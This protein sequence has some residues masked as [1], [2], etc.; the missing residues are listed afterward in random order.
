MWSAKRILAAG[1]ALAL[2][3]GLSA[4][5]TETSEMKEN[6]LT[7][8]AAEKTRTYE[9]YQMVEGNIEKTGT[10]S[11]TPIYTQTQSLCAPEDDLL[12]DRILVDRKQRVSEGEV[13]A[14][15]KQH[16]SE[17]RLAAAELALSRAQEA[18]TE[19]LETL[20]E[21]IDDAETNKGTELGD[22]RWE[23]AVLAFDRAQYNGARQLKQLQDTVDSERA[24]F[25]TVE[26]RAPFD[27]IV[28]S[29]AYLYDEQ[30]VNKK[31]AIAEISRL[32]SMALVGET[33][34]NNFQYGNDIRVE[35]GKK[36]ARSS[37]PAHVVSTSTLLG[38]DGQKIWMVLDEPMEKDDLQKPTAKVDIIQI[39]NALTVPRTA[40][41]AENGSS[42]V[43]ILVD[44]VAHKRYIIRG[45]AVGTAGE[46]HVVVLS[47]L[48]P[49]QDVILN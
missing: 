29:V 10:L 24:K 17:A 36:G 19:Q 6:I 32:S 2:F 49:G 33:A 11:L 26:L 30:E 14:T 39:R 23:L 40:I 9:T 13:V 42:Y 27:C 45:I 25:E 31:T 20:Q 22:C 18:L 44:G 28:D 34:T 46:G 1:M 3:A 8:V 12:L 47:G 48:E 4:C 5:T 37:V 16:S 38:Q 35:Y 43:Q 21:A 15:F 41:Q 7:G